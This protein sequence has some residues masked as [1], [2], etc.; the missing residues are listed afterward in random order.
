MSIQTTQ[1]PPV[2][3]GTITT[4]RAAYYAKRVKE[5]ACAVL[6]RALKDAAYDDEWHEVRGKTYKHVRRHKID[7]LR[8]LYEDPRGLLFWCR[9]ANINF[10]SLIQFLS[11]HQ[12][13]TPEMREKLHGAYVQEFDQ[14]QIQEQTNQPW[15]ENL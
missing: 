11:A 14:K 1:N 3:S 2:S 4:S 5:L 6:C 12:L 7:A 13:D 8:F 9:M 10:K 15:W